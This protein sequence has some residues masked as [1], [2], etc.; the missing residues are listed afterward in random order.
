[1]GDGGLLIADA[2]GLALDEIVPDCGGCGLDQ[3]SAISV[4]IRRG[5]EGFQR[6]QGLLDLLAGATEGRALFGHDLGVEDAGAS[7]DGKP[8][9]LRK[10]EVR[11]ALQYGAAAAKG[12][13]SRFGVPM[14]L[15]KPGYREFRYYVV[16]AHQTQKRL[17]A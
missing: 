8:M 12:K 4:L 7:L 13:R 10:A 2:A 9:A 6:R 3:T 17:V 16:T 15:M 5:V 1:M 14:P 11:H